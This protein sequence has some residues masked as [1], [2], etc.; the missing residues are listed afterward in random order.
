MLQ[1]TGES[2]DGEKSPGLGRRTHV[3]E[4]ELPLPT[5]ENRELTRVT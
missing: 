1:R 4:P 2:G 5:V 3:S